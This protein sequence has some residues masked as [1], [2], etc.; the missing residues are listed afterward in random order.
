MFSEKRYL[1]KIKVF[2]PG[3]VCP[4]EGTLFIVRSADAAD[5]CT[6]PLKDMPAVL[7]IDTDENGRYPDTDPVSR[8][9]DEKDPDTC[10][11][12]LNEVVKGSDAGTY[13]DCFRYVLEDEG[14]FDP[15][16]ADEDYLE[17]VYRRLMKIPLD[18]LETDRC[19]VRETCRD[20]LDAF[21]EIYA[22][23]SITAYT[24]DL[25]ERS[26]EEIYTDNYRDL[27]YEIYGHG[28]WTVIY[29]ETGEIIGRA[30]LDERAGSDMPELGFLIGR[31][32]QRKGLA[33]EV[34]RGI[35]KW[36]MEQGIYEVMS[37]TDPE[38]KASICLLEKLG[39]YE[40]ADP[41]EERRTCQMAHR[42]CYNLCIGPRNLADNVLS[43]G[44]K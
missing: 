26:E 11:A 36:A 10:P 42:V 2:S 30:G 6:S 5:F 35:L 34:C 16:D 9:D 28:I 20:D 24:E 39:F 18:I 1:K 7:Y 15:D 12:S 44:E 17:L 23:P 3:D 19:L 43:R 27:I 21:Y 31:K 32:W 38:N 37:F 22:E 29:K 40:T 13:R 41:G 8:N 33:E 25:M 14:D 4:Q